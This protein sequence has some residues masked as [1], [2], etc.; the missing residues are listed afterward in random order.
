MD[1]RGRGE[2]TEAPPP[3][4]DNIGYYGPEEGG[5]ANDEMLWK[6]PE[7]WRTDEEKDVF[8]PINLVAVNDPQLTEVRCMSEPVNPTP[9]LVQYEC[10]S[11]ASFRARQSGRRGVP[12]RVSEGG[13]GLP[14]S[15]FHT[16]PCPFKSVF[17]LLRCVE[18][19]QITHRPQTQWRCT[20]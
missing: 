16:E 2:E 19:A 20:K 13:G 15:D 10:L 3:Q 17:G 7:L 14:V 6:T 5:G 1:D 11:T 8:G 12:Q 4:K 9:K 18:L